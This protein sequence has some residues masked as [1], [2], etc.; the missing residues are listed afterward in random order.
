MVLRVLFLH[1]LPLKERALEHN[2]E[3]ILTSLQQRRDI[4][5]V[6]DEHVVGAEDLGPIEDDGGIRVEALEHKHLLLAGRGARGGE[7][8]AVGPVCLADPLARELVL[9]EER[10]RDHVVVQ[11]VEV[12]IGGELGDGEELAR[13]DTLELPIGAEGGD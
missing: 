6:L 1:L 7:H 2:P 9:V 5:A 11:Q 12:H 4:R 3:H 13:V 8:I 10:V